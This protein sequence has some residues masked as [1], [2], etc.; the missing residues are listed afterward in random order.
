MPPQF[1]PP[2]E[3]LAVAIVEVTVLVDTNVF[4][5]GEF[6]NAGFQKLVK[7]VERKGHRLVVPLVVVWEWAE[8]AQAAHELYRSQARFAAKRIDP[9]LRG[10]VDVPPAAD[11]EMLVALIVN[12]VTAAGGEVADPPEGSGVH[13]IR[14]QVLQIG[15][16]TKIDRV[17]TGAADALLAATVESVADDT[18]PV[19]VVSA[20]QRLGSLVHDPPR[21]RVVERVPDLWNLLLTVAPAERVVVE[22]FEKYV[23]NRIEEEIA[24]GR[25]PL[26]SG[27]PRY[28]RAVAQVLDVHDEADAFDLAILNVSAVRAVDSEVVQDDDDRFLS[29]E[30]VFVAVVGASSWRVGGPEGELISEYGEGEVQINVMATGDLDE[31]FNPVSYELDGPIRLE[32]TEPYWDEFAEQV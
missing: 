14:Q 25:H 9:L 32:V 8:H 28:D 2:C 30:L 13:A 7:R 10:A 31:E 26:P 1:G 6:S 5:N 16:G 15:H 18:P 23:L 19:V 12:A 3:D 17:K 20:D 24:D 29:A 21:V 27:S 22:R 4:A 11:I